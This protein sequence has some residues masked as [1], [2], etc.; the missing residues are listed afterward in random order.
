MNKVKNTKNGQGASEFAVSTIMGNRIDG[1]R[2]VEI[3][4]PITIITE[5][6]N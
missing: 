3:R 6:L 1:S 2:M 5:F 4:C